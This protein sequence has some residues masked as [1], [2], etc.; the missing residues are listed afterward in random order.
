M[1][2]IDRKNVRFDI[3]CAGLFFLIFII[4]ISIFQYHGVFGE[5]DL[6]RAMI[7]V[8][9]GAVTGTGYGSELHYGRD[10][11]F[12]YYGA[13][14]AF[15]PN[16]TLRDPG[17]LIKLINDI[18]YYSI[19]IGTFFFWL[20][21]LLVYGARAAFAALALYAFS[22]LILE[23]GTW[24]HQMLLAMA[25]L[26]AAAACLFWPLAGWRAFLVA[27]AGA[28]LL[29][30]G[31]TMRAEIVLAFPYLV[32]ARVKL[33]SF[34][35]F[36]RSAAINAASPAVAFIAFLAVRHSIASFP[37]KAVETTRAD[38]VIEQFFSWANVV[39]APA[40]MALGAG[41]ATVAAGAAAGIWALRRSVRPRAPDDTTIREQLI[42]PAS[43]ILVPYA[44]WMFGPIARHF[45][46][47][48]AGFSILTGWA[49]TKFSGPRF[50]PAFVSVLTLIAA[51]QVLS[52]AVRPTL[53]RMNAARS[54]Y[55]TPPEF[56]TTFTFAPLGLSWRHHAAL[57]ARWHKWNEVGDMV[58]TSCEANTVIFSDNAEQLIA[59]F[60]A[61]GGKQDR[62]N[63][64]LVHGFNAYSGNLGA[65]HYVF[66]PKLTGYPKDAVAEVLADT[67]F[68]DYKLYADPIL[69]SIYDKVAIPPARMARFGC[70]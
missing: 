69:P 65:H 67:G 23:M 42:G 18:G 41:I 64:F 6:F 49:I 54:V 44:F 5:T 2:L 53:L 13:L 27:T 37:R 70:R 35:A 30:C 14:Y 52:E 58:A 9:D 48:V 61:A 32:L 38:A 46:L 34:R 40:Y 55:R 8:I 25:F 59:R 43:L 16:A 29:I 56:L 36:V 24:G 31:L 7:G 21:V 45:I 19:I 47:A 68:D 60:F 10:F 66:I 4:Y 12:G 62:S 20:S 11:S 26:W 51:N 17:K 57:D 63:L 28:L 50:A 39:Q 1:L 3:L 33:T 15:I 22:P